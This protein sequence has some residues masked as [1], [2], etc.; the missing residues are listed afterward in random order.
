MEPQLRRPRASP[1]GFMEPLESTSIHLVQS[2]IA[3]LLQL[4][5][6]RGFVPEEADEYNRQTD[7][8]WLSVRDFL[9]FHYWANGRDGE[10]WRACREMAIPESLERRVALFGANGRIFREQR[11]AVRRGRLAAGDGGAGH[12]SGRLS[13]ARRPA[14]RRPARRVPGSREEAC[15]PCRRPASCPRRFH[16]APLRNPAQC[17]S[18]PVTDIEGRDQAEARLRADVEHQLR[19]LRDP[20]RLRAPEREH[21]PDLPVARHQ[22]RRPSRA[23]GWR[24]RSPACSSS[25][26]SAI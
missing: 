18:R 12:R 22:P 14:R 6:A 13:P 4:F 2:G 3:R 5:P 15:R 24:R 7:V 20:D 23:C 16:R 10:F 17:R 19:L 21:E 8:E 9:T 26:S 11:G 1:R 25:R